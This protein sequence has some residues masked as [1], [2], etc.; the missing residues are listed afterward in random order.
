MINIVFSPTGGTQKVADILAQA[1][2][3]EIKNID[4]TDAKIDFGNIHFDKEERAIIAVPSYGGRVP[5]LAAKRLLKLNG[6]KAECI[7]VCVYGNRAYEDTLVELRDIVEKSGFNTIAAIAAV[8][9]H[10]IIHRYAAGRPDGRD[11]EELCGFAA[12]LNKKLNNGNN[13]G[14]LQ[15]PGNRPYKK[16]GTVNLVP[17]ANG[18]CDSCGLCAAK[19]PAQA[20]SCKDN[21]VTD[22]KKCI[23]CMRCVR[24]C[25]KSAR[26]INKI[27]VFAAAMAIKNSC[28]ERKN[29]ELFV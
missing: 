17:K 7:I 3:S 5:S 2:S 24:I 26:K 10:S 29:N 1:M 21:R 13:D 4:L 27:M 16:T 25:P 20:I 6:N 12:R 14:N 18:K 15:L 22:S 19:C 11:K 9:E 8:A 23:G 28:K